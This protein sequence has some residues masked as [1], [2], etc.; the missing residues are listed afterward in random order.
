[1][2]GAEPVGY[3]GKGQQPPE[4]ATRGPWG[5]CS[6]AGTKPTWPANH[7]WCGRSQNG[8]S[9]VGAGRESRLQMNSTIQPIDTPCHRP[10]AHGHPPPKGARG[11]SLHFRRTARPIDRD[12]NRRAWGV[13]ARGL[14]AEVS[15]GSVA[16]EA[17]MPGSGLSGSRGQ[18]LPRSGPAGWFTE[19]FT[20][21]R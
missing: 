16:A 7:P 5:V 13:P 14:R 17:N 15:R 2:G 20:N 10:G 18:L 3:G 1:M 9:I 4:T 6:A 21:N 12:A 8:A 19:S 11:D